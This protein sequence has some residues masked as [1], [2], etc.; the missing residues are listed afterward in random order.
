ME[1]S[2]YFYIS[3]NRIDYSYSALIWGIKLKI[4]YEALAFQ[5][6]LVIDNLCHEVEHT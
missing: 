2:V 1:I 3:P 6:A 4:K 5:A